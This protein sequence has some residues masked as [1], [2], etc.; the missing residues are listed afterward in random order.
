[1]QAA[2]W[3]QTDGTPPAAIGG[4]EEVRALM[5]AAG[6]S[7]NTA[8]TDLPA[9]ANPNG[10]S[11]NTGAVSASGD[12]LPNSLVAAVEEPAIV[13]LDAAQL[14]TKRFQAGKK[15]FGDLVVAANGNVDHLDLT[16]ERKV[17]K[18]WKA[19][20]KLPT[21]KFEAGTTALQVP[22][23]RLAVGKYRLVVSVGGP[24]GEPEGRTV[25]FSAGK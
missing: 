15:A 1:M 25:G 6:V 14:Y 7:E 22:L 3:N 18:R 23:G 19:T 4:P 21:R 20:K 13:R 16:V 2:I 12:V 5:S 8:G 24:V 10:G 11:P 9:I 17:G